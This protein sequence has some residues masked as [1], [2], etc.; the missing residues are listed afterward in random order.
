MEILNIFHFA[1]LEKAHYCSIYNFNIAA[2]LQVQIDFCINAHCVVVKVLI[3]PT[4]EGLLQTLSVL[5][6]KVIRKLYI[7][8]YEEQY[9]LC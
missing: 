9:Y 8:I 4:K 1:L 5:S 6:Y 3:I 7:L 2:L